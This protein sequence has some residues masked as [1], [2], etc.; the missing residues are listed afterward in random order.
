MKNELTKILNKHIDNI[1]HDKD[2]YRMGIKSEVRITL[3]KELEQELQ[4]HL[5]D[6]IAKGIKGFSDFIVSELSQNP[7]TNNRT[8]KNAIGVMRNKY[9]KGLKDE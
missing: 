5:A 6:E 2:L 8:I 4:Q 9:L 3:P 1:I 7:F